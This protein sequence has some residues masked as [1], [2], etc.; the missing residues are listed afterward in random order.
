[1]GPDEFAWLDLRTYPA[2]LQ[3]LISLRSASATLLSA[4]MY[5]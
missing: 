1:M 5:R 3:L 2:G 4:I